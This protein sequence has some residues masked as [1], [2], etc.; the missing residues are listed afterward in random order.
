MNTTNGKLNNSISKILILLCVDKYF[1]AG[2]P[3]NV[4]PID[5]LKDRTTLP[6]I[7]CIEYDIKVVAHF[8][9]SYHYIFV[10]LFT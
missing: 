10:I 8:K 9:V 5:V 1:L 3:H 7:Q 6:V 2:V 4:S